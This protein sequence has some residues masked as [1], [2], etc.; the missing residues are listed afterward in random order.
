[1]FSSTAWTSCSSGLK[2]YFGMSHASA[3]LPQELPT[4]RGK[5]PTF[6]RFRL[7]NLLL[8]LNQNQESFLRE[9]SSFAFIF[10]SR[11]NQTGKHRRRSLKRLLAG[12]V[13]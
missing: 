2:L 5:K 8:V 9:I 10:L 4:Q 3:D 13:S 12:P 7:L 6:D 1:M 11:Q